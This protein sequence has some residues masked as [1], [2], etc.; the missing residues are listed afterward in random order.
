MTVYLPMKVLYAFKEQ[1]GLHLSFRQKVPFSFTLFNIA[2]LQAYN[3]TLFDCCFNLRR[4]GFLNQTY[5]HLTLVKGAYYPVSTQSNPRIK[6]FAPS[7]E[8]VLKFENKKN[9]TL[10][11]DQKLVFKAT[12]SNQ[13]FQPAS[14]SYLL[15]SDKI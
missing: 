11:K 10:Q 3:T 13:I 15:M 14:V 8:Y 6:Y 7:V 2:I 9:C 1:E 5:K 12:N 4:N